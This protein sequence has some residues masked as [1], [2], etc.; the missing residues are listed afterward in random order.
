MFSLTL[1]FV[2]HGQRTLLPTKACRIAHPLHSVPGPTMTPYSGPTGRF[3]RTG[4]IAY[5]GSARWEELRPLITSLYVDKDMKLA[6]VQQ[7]LQHHH[8]FAAT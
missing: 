5:D 2:L 7:F 1:T 3:G 8:K 4:D 6:E